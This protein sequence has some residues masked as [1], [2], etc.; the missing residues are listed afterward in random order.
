[1]L[2]DLTS[3]GSLESFD[4]WVGSKAGSISRKNDI[5]I[6]DG[7][8]LEIGIRSP[9]GI[10][11]DMTDVTGELRSAEFIDFKDVKQLASGKSY[12][13]RPRMDADKFINFHNYHWI[14]TDVPAIMLDPGFLDN[15]GQATV[16]IV[17]DILGNAYY[18]TYTQENGNKLELRNGMK[19]YFVNRGGNGTWVD[20]VRYITKPTDTA[21]R[22]FVVEGVGDAIRLLDYNLYCN[23]VSLISSLDYDANG[24]T[25]FN[26]SGK[27]YTTIARGSNNYNAWS[28]N[29]RWYHEQTVL[30]IARFMEVDAETIISNDTRAHRPII[31]FDA[32]I[33]LW[34]HGYIGKTPVD[35]VS[36]EISSFY[37]YN[38]TVNPVIDGYTLA[39]GDRVLF[40]M[41]DSAIENKIFQAVNVTTGVSF[42][43]TTDSNPR[44]GENLLVLNGDNNQGSSYYFNGNNWV[45]GQDLT[46][47]AQ[48]PL[49]RLFDQ[50]GTPI[51][52]YNT[53]AFAG[54]QIFGY[55]QGNV[56]DRELGFDP[57]VNGYGVAFDSNYKGSIQYN[58]GAAKFTNYIGQK[59]QQ[60]VGPYSTLVEIMSENYYRI[61][62][63]F[64]DT[65]VYK[66]V[67]VPLSDTF[68]VKSTHSMTAQSD[69]DLEL[70]D[71]KFVFSPPYAWNILKWQHSGIADNYPGILLIQEAIGTQ[72]PR[73]WYDTLLIA[74]FRD[75]F[76]FN[77]TG[78]AFQ[79]ANQRGDIIIS[80]TNITVPIPKSLFDAGTDILPDDYVI[81]WRI[82]LYGSWQTANIIARSK[83]DPRRP[84]IFVNGTLATTEKW[85]IND[86]IGLTVHD[87]SAGDMID[88]TVNGSM[89][90]DTTSDS[91][92]SNLEK[93]PYNDTFDIGSYG[94]L[95]PQ[96]I[97]QLKKSTIPLFI[98]DSH[99][100]NIQFPRFPADGSSPVFGDTDYDYSSNSTQRAGN[101]ILKHDHP[102]NRFFW[103][104]RSGQTGSIFSLLEDARKA[105]NGFKLRLIQKIEQIHLDQLT[106]DASSVLDKA[107]SEIFVGRD[108]TFRYA[109]SHM[110]MWGIPKASKTYTSGNLSGALTLDIPGSN[111]ML[112]EIQSDH[113]YVYMKSSVSGINQILSYQT[114]YDIDIN[115]NQVTILDA[116]VDSFYTIKVYDNATTSFVPPTPTK[117]GIT[118]LF[119]P[120]IIA[121]NTYLSGTVNFIQGHDGSLIPAWNDYRDDVFLEFENRIAGNV[122]NARA[123]L[124]EELISSIYPKKDRSTWYNKDEITGYLKEHWLTWANENN[125]V[126]TPNEGATFGYPFTYNYSFFAAA[127]GN[128]YGSWRDLYRYIYGT[129]RPHT[130][131]W[132]ILGMSRKPSW[133]DSCYSWTDT[134]KRNQLMLSLLYGDRSPAGNR[135]E[136]GVKY[137]IRSAWL[138]LMPVDEN[139]DL[140]DPIAAGWY[141]QTVI[142]TQSD[143]VKDTWQYGQLGTQELAWRRSSDFNFSVAIWLLLTGGPSYLEAVWEGPRQISS[144]IAPE[145]NIDR[146]Y[147]F[148]S[149]WAT[150]NQHRETAGDVVPG[151]GMLVNEQAASLLG[152]NLIDVIND[153]RHVKSRLQWTAN[154]FLQSAS[155]RFLADILVEQDKGNQ[156]PEENC[157]IYMKVTSPDQVITY[158]GVKVIQDVSGGYRI[159]GY[160]DVSTY[161]P[162]Y[163]V[164]TSGMNHTK[165]QV[166]N[167][168]YLYYFNFKKDIAYLNY[169]TV[170]PTRQDV[171]NFLIGYGRYQESLGWVFD[172][173]APTD[174][175]ILDWGYSAKE[176]ATWSQTRWQENTQIALSPG[177]QH[178][179]LTHATRFF[180]RLDTTFL[181]KSYLLDNEKKLIEFKNTEIIRGI[182]NTV[183]R[184]RPGVGIYFV[185][186]GLEEYTHAVIFDDVT[187]FDD[188]VHNS[189][190]GYHM[191]RLRV[192][193][194]RV[195]SWNGKPN[196]NGYLL[197]NR[198]V[199]SNFDTISREIGDDYISI[200]NR[201]ANSW[202]ADL[203]K[204]QQGQIIP[205]NTLLNTGWS[206]DTVDQFEVAGLRRKGTPNIIE[207]FAKGLLGDSPNPQGLP[208][209][210]GISVKEDWMFRMGEDFGNVG[211]KITWEI[212]IPQ[213]EKDILLNTFIIREIPE[214]ASGTYYD[215]NHDRQFDNIVDLLG[216]NDSRWVRHPTALS[217]PL[218][219]AALQDGDMPQAGIA[220][221]F[222][223]DY[224]FMDI[225]G[226]LTIDK[227]DA[228]MGQFFLP[229]RWDP[230]VGYDKQDVVRYNGLL[231][232]CLM[233]HA[234]TAIFDIQ[235]WM[236]IPEFI[237]PSYWLAKKDLGS[238]DVRDWTIYQTMDQ[239]L[240]IREICG[241][242]AT[243]PY[244]PLVEMV[245][246]FKHNLLPGDW[247]IIA[248]TEKS[249]VL[250]GYYQVASIRDTESFFIQLMPNPTT[251]SYPAFGIG[252]TSMGGKLF[253]V[254]EVH[255]YTIAEMKNSLIS[256]RY[257]W[258]DGMKAYV[259]NRID[260]A[261][262]FVFGGDYQFASYP[263]ANGRRGMV[264]YDLTN[265]HVL[266]ESMNS[267]QEYMPWLF[268]IGMLLA[269]F[270]QI[271]LG[272]LK[273][274]DLCTVSRNALLVPQPKLPNFDNVPS[275]TVCDCLNGIVFRQ[276][277]DCALILA[278]KIYGNVAN[279]I[280]AVNTMFSADCL[281]ESAYIDAKTSIGY[282][283]AMDLTNIAK[284]IWDTYPNLQAIFAT[285]S[286]FFRGMI[287]ANNSDLNIKGNGIGM[288]AIEN[289]AIDS[290]TTEYH[291][292]G[293]KTYGTREL[294]LVSMGY[295]SR[296]ARDGDAM[297][298]LDTVSRFGM[299]PGNFTTVP[300][301]IDRKLTD[302]VDHSR[303]TKVE[304]VDYVNN[305]VLA[306]LQAFD[307]ITGTLPGYVNSLIDWKHSF[308][309]ANYTNGD[310]TNYLGYTVR[311]R[312]AWFDEHIGEIWWDL[313]T[314]RY[315]DYYQGTTRERAYQWGRQFPGS[316]VDMY[317]WIKTTVTPS[318]WVNSALTGQLVDLKNV[319]GTP[320]HIVDDSGNS[321]YFWSERVEKDSSGILKTFY[322]YWVKGLTYSNQE[323][324]STTLLS[325]KSTAGLS[326][327]AYSSGVNGVNTSPPVITV[328]EI[329]NTIN[330]PKITG[331]RWFA[332]LQSNAMIIAGCSDLLQ[333]PGAVI[334]IQ[335]D[336]TTDEHSQ[337]LLLKENDTTSI[338]PDWLHIRLRD[339]II[340]TDQN[341]V[342]YTF[343]PYVSGIIYLQ[344][345]VVISNGNFYRAYRDFKIGDARFRDSTHVKF[346]DQPWQRIWEY[347]QIDLDK[348]TEMQGK[349]VPNYNRHPF[350][351]YGNEIRPSQQSWL[352]SR[353]DAIRVLV[354]VANQELASFPVTSVASWDK[355]LNEVI[356]T[357]D[358][359]LVYNMSDYWYYADY[360]DPSYNISMG[361]SVKFNSLAELY[362]DTSLNEGEYAAVRVGSQKLLNV[363]QRLSLGW[364]IVYQQK[365]TIQ[366]DKKLFDIARRQELWDSTPWDTLRWDA[367]PF[368]ALSEIITAL[369]EDIFVNTHQVSYS[370]LFFA[371][372]KETLRQ[373]SEC[374]WIRKSTYV[375]I[376]TT[377]TD[378]YQQD[379]YFRK[380]YLRND[381]GLLI[382]FVNQVKPY[383]TK[384][385]NQIEVDQLLE[386]TNL[387]VNDDNRVMN[388]TIKI[389]DLG[390]KQWTQYYID[391]HPFQHLQ[392]G[393]DRN[394]WDLEFTSVGKLPSSHK[395]V[396]RLKQYLWDMDQ[397]RYNELIDTI[398]NGY[399]FGLQPEDLQVI[400]EGNAFYQPKYDRW[401]SCMVPLSPGESIEIRVMDNVSG[402]TVD[403]NTLAWRYHMDI[404][405]GLRVYRYNTEATATLDGAIDYN[406]T[407][408]TVN[409]ATVLTQ[410]DPVNGKPGVIWIENERIVFYKVVDNTLTDLVRG[411]LGTSATAHGD[412][413]K[414][415]DGG[416][417]NIVTTPENLHNWNNILYPMWNTSGHRLADS[418]TSEAVFLK[419][420]PGYFDV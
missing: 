80:S 292:I 391:G 236:T 420:K 383:H 246:G 131:P 26:A 201:S 54:N 399:S 382:D 21:P 41:A 64:N 122:G 159:D 104:M 241:G 337:W 170:L 268:P 226:L 328:S 368:M 354:D 9:M 68:L 325:I 314:V 321:K 339:S 360:A 230:T 362:Q 83:D 320:Y 227:T 31:E 220:N 196:A 180:G 278:E 364:M 302:I 86:G 240:A 261:E 402:S 11:G 419:K 105:Y 316:S 145:I 143:S 173:L 387:S 396:S 346:A 89:I 186:V 45:Q 417:M 46:D 338:V 350:N 71:L 340:G 265:N 184:S 157:H 392:E 233:S 284:Y 202:I 76:I 270:E 74:R 255:F 14:N 414:V 13:Y 276:F 275:I 156:L 263:V 234:A 332:G 70:S 343:T 287:Y 117:L 405:G 110:V 92:L 195:P 39:E 1:L 393:W 394:L 370:R 222:D 82:G 331:A 224:Q 273:L 384:V 293:I 304:I 232:T 250:D 98:S 132:E 24:N 312:T 375:D 197:A 363:W 307:P 137:R 357:Q 135:W 51:E 235:N 404:L 62:N 167:I 22:Y 165:I 330:N 211:E 257:G 96:F 349:S 158:S 335:V 356:T 174:S 406:T 66:S 237:L 171:I 188:I 308:D 249:D 410:P 129:D 279:A 323:R 48:S 15:G 84:D 212:K 353:L 119:V 146:E 49:F 372:V 169:G 115:S 85:D 218:R 38:G 100:A 288:M 77:Y 138:R 33:E 34:D 52:D 163:P 2:G 126:F 342:I 299:G 161:F 408:I 3:K 93:N 177:S 398:V 19:I 114:D 295:G 277:N 315:F 140:M 247:V 58:M 280:A 395:V 229:T 345:D 269:T 369:R 358:P 409:D 388:I 59:Y 400:I 175:E 109:Y 416:Q 176:F 389:D 90:N 291:Q 381:D 412:S 411:T 29:N 17:A 380:Q 125:I 336:G 347:T 348:I 373:N 130:H 107:L 88:I 418:T 67:W 283:T 221:R 365:G 251:Y 300:F 56:A 228:T 133:W 94:S 341:T 192:Q 207:K 378:E 334:R 374:H 352:K 16:N 407:S 262:V 113:V 366:L 193:G 162:Y 282:G 200:E 37:Y 377:T 309:P 214:F 20:G 124:S 6:N 75:N 4:G 91:S 252:Q 310:D 191:D 187:T 155:L 178:L 376:V 344:N 248:S 30:E 361:Y 333:K 322:Y 199:L 97:S 154:N 181:N 245:S 55:T 259:D 179:T 219:S 27:Q 99:H 239:N 313:S 152:T 301:V 190:F 260:N 95:F 139:G 296:A 28:R 267:R 23:P 12:S 127:D 253:P 32:N 203:K 194:L 57:A 205:D 254:R 351:R 108:D 303:I 142:G 60:A 355:R 7:N 390:N 256:P 294:M 243:N 81:R 318:Q 210:A 189:L 413:T 379:P 147:G 149:T 123:L 285:N 297:V 326:N 198:T 87:L 79:V 10:I 216:P 274:L 327:V 134:Y 185:R 329:A 5:Y 223:A 18:T 271:K 290:V 168:S 53:T 106:E 25:I 217:L 306:E 40:L 72:P 359:T 264:F 116:A 50:N 385:L 208:F 128:F 150:A 206:Q 43:P 272:K 172:D 65:W 69:G 183:L 111:T 242:T 319:S 136:T 266:H 118:P 36:T 386:N 305:V 148:I 415:Y 215:G 401:P 44:F 121:D 112:G 311:P 73:N 298:L 42:V 403:A 78:L 397:P 244:Q 213:Q 47:R 238:N 281:A 286:W 231:F 61:Y 367:Y 153:T 144:P 101:H 317:E 63:Q 182:D 371:L 258:Q 120:G 8:R 324:P 151:F 166:G 103:T 141:D 160:D 102:A 164:D 289:I 209:D 35:A 204:S 225:N